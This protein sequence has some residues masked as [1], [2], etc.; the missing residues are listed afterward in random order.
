[1][2][3]MP[4]FLIIASGLFE[5][6]LLANFQKK[7]GGLDNKM[8]ESEH[9]IRE[10]EVSIEK[11]LEE[12]SRVKEEIEKAKQELSGLDKEREVQERKLLALKVEHTVAEE[13][14]EE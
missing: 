8:R 9:Q 12:E 10:S 2:D 13:Q 14:E 5:V 6:P 11:F 4:V 7:M 1:M 3:W